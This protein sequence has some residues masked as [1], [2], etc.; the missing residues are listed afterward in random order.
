MMD[1]AEEQELVS[2]RFSI[3]LVDEFRTSKTSQELKRYRKKDGR[4]SYSRL[5]CTCGSETS[6]KL[7]MRFV[8]R[9]L[10]AAANI[11]LAGTSPSRPAYLSQARKR[12]SEDGR[13]QSPLPLQ[14]RLKAAEVSEL[15]E[16]TRRPVDAGRKLSDPTFLVLC[17]D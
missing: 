6:H 2:K 13:S 12:L 5:Y 4:L 8:D 11:L 14:K 15:R 7:S 10:N 16:P 3:S 9:D 17:V 1:Q